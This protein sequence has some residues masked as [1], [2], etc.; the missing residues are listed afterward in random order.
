MHKVVK[1]KRITLKTADL[2]LATV[3]Y[4][5]D[6]FHRDA[7]EQ[8]DKEFAT[9]SAAQ[10]WLEKFP[11]DIWD[12]YDSSDFNYQEPDENDYVNK[13][14]PP[15]RNRSTAKGSQFG[16]ELVSRKIGPVL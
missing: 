1:D 8:I 4:F 13:R 15:I 7:H 2:Y 14:R 5:Q 9:I 16:R 6:T 3:E 12:G 10:K 11:R